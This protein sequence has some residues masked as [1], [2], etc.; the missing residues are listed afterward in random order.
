MLSGIEQFRVEA[1][2]ALLAGRMAR[3][4][5]Q[6]VAPPGRLQVAHFASRYKHRRVRSLHAGKEQLTLGA[7][8]DLAL[9]PVEPSLP[10]RLSASVELHRHSR[11]WIHALQRR[12]CSRHRR[13]HYRVEPPPGYDD[14][15]HAVL[16][17]EHAV[18]SSQAARLGL[19]ITAYM[20]ATFV[21]PQDF[22]PAWQMGLIL[23]W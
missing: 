20:R 12:L 4:M 3:R 16:L 17:T 10:P 2:T 21:R 6:T 11:W 9:P 8:D 23:R 19:N 5:R 18:L 1:V 7:A 22:P 15:G 14:P 13:G